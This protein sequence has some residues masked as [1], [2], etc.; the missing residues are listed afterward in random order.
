MLKRLNESIPSYLKLSVIMLG[1]VAFFFTIYV[2]Q[3]ILV[4]LVFA[5][6]VA[7]LL[8]PF[9]NFLTSKKINR[10]VSIV[11]ALS[12][13]LLL[14]AGLIIFISSQFHKFG[15]ALPQLK[16]RVTQ[17][18]R[19]VTM[20]GAET[21]NLSYA[22]MNSWIEKGKDEGM[23]SGKE[24]LGNTVN[25]LSHFLILLLLIPVYIFLLLFYKPL[26]L[27]FISKLFST[28]KHT[29]VIDI[30]AESKILIQQYL[31]GI[32]TEMAIVSTLTSIGL[33]FIG[34]QS[35]ILFGVITGLLNMI[36]YVGVLVA[37]ILFATIALVTKSV[38]AG[39]L[40]LG[41]YVLVQFIDN[42]FIVPRIVGSKVQ[43]NALATILVVLIGG[44]LCGVAG[45]FLAIPVTAVFKV[46]CDRVEPLEPLGYML[47]DTMPSPKNKIFNVRWP[48]KTASEKKAE[49]K[50]NEESRSNDK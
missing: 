39:V 29:T 13:A 35:P 44:E 5:I 7:M 8:N 10:V 28:D 20:W 38:T 26:I 11:I 21:F 6:L 34:I 31:I 18:Y 43:I 3:A 19:E 47:G 22:K 15:D 12:C 40:T 41:L 2:A 32:M 45:M 27:K 1:L 48:V 46:I 4:P 24:V 17:L 25:T 36:P 16:E 42:N 23:S 49:D 9:V 14:M 50:K 33:F 37:N 30:L